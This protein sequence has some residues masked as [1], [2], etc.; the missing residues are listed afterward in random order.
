MNTLRKILIVDDEKMNIIALGHFLKPYYEIIIA[1]NGIS[2]IE[3]AEKN[4]PELILLDII[5]PEMDGFEVITRLKT[6]KITK[7]IPV[8]FISGLDEESYVEK[9]FALGAADFLIKPFNRF[10]VKSRVDTQFKLAENK[11]VIEALKK[12][13]NNAD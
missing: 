4:A 7:D 6:S 11:Q 10:L 1:T 13:Q 2:A 9:G 8:V 3:I 5:M 12:Q